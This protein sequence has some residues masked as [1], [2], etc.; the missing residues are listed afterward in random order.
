MKWAL[1]IIVAVIVLVVSGTFS[2]LVNARLE[3]RAAA[4]RREF[5]DK[6]GRGEVL[7]ALRY[8][9]Q[10]PALILAVTHSGKVTECRD[11]GGPVLAA[12]L[13]PGSCPEMRQEVQA[14]WESGAEATVGFTYSCIP[15][16]NIEY[17]DVEKIDAVSR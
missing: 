13:M 1:G 16:L 8:G 6:I 9:P 12:S 5:C 2:S 11:K 10:T 15:M 14:R 7:G 3:A 17:L 4:A